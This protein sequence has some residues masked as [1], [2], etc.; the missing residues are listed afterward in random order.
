METHGIGNTLEE[1]LIGIHLLCLF[2]FNPNMF[3]HFIFLVKIDFIGGCWHWII[4][5]QCINIDT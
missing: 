5:L 4:F 3:F 1:C 2:T